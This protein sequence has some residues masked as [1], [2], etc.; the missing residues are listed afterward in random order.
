MYP[1]VV[2]GRLGEQVDLLLGDVPPIAVTQVL[3]GVRL[4]CGD[5]GVDLRYAGRL[6]HAGTFFS[7][8]CS[9]A[10]PPMIFALA[11]LDRPSSRSTKLSGSPMPSGCGK[12]EPNI[13]WSSPMMS[14]IPL[15]SSSRNG[16]M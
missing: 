3:A 2:A 10:L 13:T 8:S 15:T 7:P 5:P 9:I 12:S 16:W 11:V 6:C 1:L 4:E 14:T